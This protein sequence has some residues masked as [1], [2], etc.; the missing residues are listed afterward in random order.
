MFRYAA[1]C[2]IWIWGSIVTKG[3]NLFKGNV[4]LA[5]ETNFQN[6]LILDGLKHTLMRLKKAGKNI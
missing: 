6:Y 3:L 2:W 1:F 4:E 5:G